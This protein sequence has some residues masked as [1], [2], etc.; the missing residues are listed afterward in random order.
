MYLLPVGF[1]FFSCSLHVEVTTGPRPRN[2]Q[3]WEHLPSV[4]F[5]LSPLLV[6]R[7]SQLLE[8]EARLVLDKP[9]A[10]PSLRNEATPSPSGQGTSTQNASR[11]SIHRLIALTSANAVS[12]SSFPSLSA[13][14]NSVVEGTARHHVDVMHERAGRGMHPAGPLHQ[15]SEAGRSGEAPATARLIR[16]QTFEKPELLAKELDHE[17]HRNTATQTAADDRDLLARLHM[18]IVHFL[19]DLLVHRGGRLEDASVDLAAKEGDTL[20]V[21][22]RERVLDSSSAAD[23]EL[24]LIRLLVDGRGNSSAPTLLRRTPRAKCPHRHGRQYKRFSALCLSSGWTVH[25]QRVSERH[26]VEALHESVRVA[27]HNRDCLSLESCSMMYSRVFKKSTFRMRSTSSRT[28][29]CR[30][31]TLSPEVWS[32]YGSKRPGV[33]VSDVSSAHGTPTPNSWSSST[34]PK[35]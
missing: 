9:P 27:E 20:D 10:P 4:S 8:P 3:P 30:S 21:D 31:S 16:F 24:N 26:A 12:F 25:Q 23:G 11:V 14:F 19:G 15:W 2:A 33:S 18:Q 22:V 7:V 35:T 5:S 28:N 29:I 13:V 6:R 1:C 32:R 17:E 34:I